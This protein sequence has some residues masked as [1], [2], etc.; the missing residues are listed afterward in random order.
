M[1]VTNKDPNDLNFY[2]QSL[3]KTDVIYDRNLLG[4][5]IYPNVFSRPQKL[6]KYELDYLLNKAN[7]LGV[8]IIILTSKP[9]DLKNRLNKKE[10]FSCVRENIEEI[11]N[12]F[13]QLAGEYNI[14]VINTS[15]RG[16][17]ETF[18]EAIK[19]ITKLN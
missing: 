3:R 14:P 1:H 15:T 16:I 8:V 5:M 19:C 2:Y 12:K 9:E 17:K 10:E 11:N 13:L 7:E 18:E 6:K 4:E